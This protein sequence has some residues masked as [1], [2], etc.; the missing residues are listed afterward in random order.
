[1]DD[2]HRAQRLAGLAKANE[3]RAERKRLKRRIAIGEV[4]ALELLA[5]PPD[6]VS[7]MPVR[8]LLMWVPKVGKV[9]VRRTIARVNA[10]IGG[11]ILDGATLVGR[12][13][14]STRQRLIDELT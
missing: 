3:V 14:P 8:E 1:M 13:G 2:P 6:V 11:Q 10:S 12:L 9:K 5:D 7:N 4:D